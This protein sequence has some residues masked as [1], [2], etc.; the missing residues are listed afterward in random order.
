M[1][2]I[3]KNQRPDKKPAIKKSRSFWKIFFISCLFLALTG[4]LLSSLGATVLYFKYSKDLPDVRMLKEYHPSTITKLFSDNDELIAEFYIEKRIIIPDEKIPLQ[5]KQATLAV[6]DSHFYYHF[7]ID[8][9]AIVRAFFVNLKAGAVVEGGSTIT[10]QLSK[11]LFLTRDRTITRKI[12]EAI[13]AIRLELIFSKDEILGMYLN[14]IYYGHGSYGVEAASRTYFGKSAKD[15]TFD[16]C[17]LLASLPKAPNNYTP[18]RYPERAKK[19]RNHAL[20]RMA[21]LGFITKTQAED[22]QKL[23]FQLGEITGMLNKAPYFVEHIRQFLQDTYGSKKMYRDGLSVYTT[24]NMDYQEVA[25]QA[26]RENLLIAD[27][28]Y[29]YRGP[30]GT[31]ELSQNPLVIQTTLRELNGFEEDENAGPEQGAILKGAV[32]EVTDDDVLVG[33]GKDEGI[34]ELKDMDWARKPNIR[35]DGRWAKISSPKRALSKGDLILVKVLGPREEDMR[36]SLSLEQE[37]AVEAGLI[38][39]EAGTGHIKAM[40]GGYNFSKSQFNRAVQALRQPGSAFKPIIYASAIKEGF[41]PASIVIDSPI[42]FKEKIDAFDQWKPV[43]FEKKFYGPTSLRTAL[44]HSRNIVTVKLLQEIGVGRAVQMARDL[45][46]S[47]P[48]ANNLSISLGSSGMTL[49]DL[50]SAYSSFANRGERVSPTAVRLIENRSG[51]LLYSAQPHVTQPISSG[52]AY[53]ITS[54]MQSVVQ[55][56]TATKVKV[57]NRPLA[58]KTGTTNNNVDAWFIGFSPE[59][60]TGVWVGRDD[61]EPLG[62]NETGSRAA[63]P[64]WL[65]FMKHVLRDTP[66]LNF[67]VSRDVV[68]TKINPETGDKANFADP[69]SRFEVFMDE[70]DEDVLESGL[71]NL[72]PEE[73]DTF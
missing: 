25:Q 10:Q 36:W 47:S 67:P 44:T 1:K 30:L 35:V 62:V 72:E 52:L 34:I 64:I 48:L 56:G 43:N 3:F 70:F 33:L 21:S 40:V 58:G 45:G 51:E 7:G 11:T 73:E 26:I 4:L 38:S 27:K 63:I 12:K 29:G 16:E 2:K 60:V 32:L 23:G 68:F 65:Q 55:H 61:Y 15:L 20:R 22:G 9:K 41:T 54:L 69:G 6:E 50:T 37:P 31:V 57:L 53:T 5:L 14:Q 42:I 8:P 39:L 24:L 17:A 49:L 46:I 18:Y 71:A 59:I 19:R 66:I 28:R 13:L